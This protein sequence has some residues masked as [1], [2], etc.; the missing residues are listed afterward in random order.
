MSMTSAGEP[1]TTT[2]TKS[3]RTSCWASTKDVC[4]F[5]R[6]NGFSVA[7]KGAGAMDLCVFER[8]AVFLSRVRRAIGSCDGDSKAALV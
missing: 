1:S 5:C 3:R 6:N 7:S 8:G 2:A 4:S